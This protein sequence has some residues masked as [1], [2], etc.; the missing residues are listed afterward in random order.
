MFKIRDIVR[1]L[2]PPAAV[3]SQP[4]HFLIIP[5]A[6]ILVECERLLAEEEEAHPIAEITR[7]PSGAAYTSNP[8]L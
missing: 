3:A 1:L 2:H 7:R 8:M 6:D 4:V 5:L